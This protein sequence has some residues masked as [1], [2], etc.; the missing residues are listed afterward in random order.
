MIGL[1]YSN[2]ILLFA[3]SHVLFLQY[4]CLYQNSH[5][6][7]S[8]SYKTVPIFCC[9]FAHSHFLC[10]FLCLMNYKPTNIIYLDGRCTFSFPHSTLG[11]KYIFYKPIGYLRTV[12]IYN[13]TMSEDIY[14][15]WREG[16]FKL[17]K[18]SLAQN[19]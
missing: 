9:N 13:A 5:T 15:V 10:V 8:L 6:Y 14:F 3:L 18:K 17:S 19:L 11:I 7:F 16:V 12:Y 1:F 2:F 4:A